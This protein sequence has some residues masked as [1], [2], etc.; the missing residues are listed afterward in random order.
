MVR[1]VEVDLEPAIDQHAAES[2][3]GVARAHARQPAHV[4]SPDGD[5]PLAVDGGRLEG[6]RGGVDACR[7]R[8]E[9]LVGGVGVGEPAEPIPV[10]VARAGQPGREP[11]DAGGRGVG[12]PGRE[13]VVLAGEFEAVHAR[14][15]VRGRKE[16]TAPLPSPTHCR[17]I[18]P[19]GPTNLFKPHR[20]PLKR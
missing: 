6:D 7:R 2:A 5:G 8:R 17:R 10:D 14:V 12:L 3:L 4:A 18:R 9:Q 20:R 13:G 16:A 1:I 15:W 19:V 11:F